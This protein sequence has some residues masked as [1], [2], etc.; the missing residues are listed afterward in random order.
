[1]HVVR[2]LSRRRV[3]LVNQPT[4]GGSRTEN[5]CPGWQIVCGEEFKSFVVDLVVVAAQ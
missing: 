5:L 3:E 1:M 2:K 4:T